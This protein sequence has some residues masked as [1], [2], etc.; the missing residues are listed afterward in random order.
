MPVDLSPE[1]RRSLDEVERAH[2]M[3]VL[4]ACHN[5]RRDAAR[6]LGIDRKTLAR[7]L[8]RWGIDLP[9]EGRPLAAG[10][11]IAIEGLDG[12][13]ITTQARHLADYLNA[14]GHAALYT[15]QPSSGQVGRL[16]RD[17]LASS[18]E[19]D[20][21]GATRVLSL[22]FAADRI[23]HFNRVVA[24]ALAQRIT[25]VTDRWYHSSLAYQRR[26]VQRD[27][28][29]S[30]NRHARTPDVT[31][32][33][34]VRPE[35]AEARRRAAGRAQ[36]LFHDLA[37]QREVANAYRATISELRIDGER[38]A[39]VDGELG[40]GVV[41]AAIIAALGFDARPSTAEANE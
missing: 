36:E 2:V 40:E 12:A 9:R 21:D 14:R 35:V 1:L 27:W 25:V 38:I 4:G 16:I 37:T 24:P 34:D 7:S 19:L 41:A 13:G 26:G 28:I 11:L 8:V 33:L 15:A 31:V 32:Y 39:V 6:I 30:L 29:T 20:H 10:S 5:N 3:S 17:M 23:Q 18:D 22:L